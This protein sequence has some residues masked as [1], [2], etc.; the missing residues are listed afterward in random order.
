MTYTG[1][2]MAKKKVKTKPSTEKKVTR[3][4]DNL[5]D[6]YRALEKDLEDRELFDAYYVERK[7]SPA[8]ELKAA[9]E[10]GSEP[11]KILFSGQPKSGKTTELLRL[12][13]ELEETHLS[14]FMSVLRDLEP[15]DV[16]ALD[17]LLFSVI[18]LAGEAQEAGIKLGRDIKKLLTDLLLRSTSEVF[19]ERVITKAGGGKVGFK[20]PFA[21]AELG[22][23]YGIE[24]SLREVVRE[25]LGPKIGELVEVFNMVAAR[26]RQETG[27]EPLVVID[28]MEKLD[29]KLVDELFRLQAA[30]LARPKCRMIYTVSKAME[31]LP[32]WKMVL[33]SFD[34]LVEVYP[35]RIA[36]RDGAPHEDGLELLRNILRRRMSE[37]LFETDAFSKVV[38]VCNGVLSDLFSVCRDA[39]VSAKVAGT[40]RITWD[41]VD[42][43]AM[44]LTIHFQ[45]MI[46]ED[47]Y[48]VL[49]EVHKTRTGKKDEPLSKLLHMLAVIEYRDAEGIYYD[50]HPAVVPLLER[51]KLA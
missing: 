46:D 35:V 48:P 42:R 6:A 19:K 38:T 43:H 39:C 15:G 4:A 36:K 3:P 16:A 9:L 13:R 45:R 1:S 29:L 23:S 34:K 37:D 10:M 31:Y 7:Y 2:I 20:L 47:L 44:N 30:T 50:V 33:G 40:G 14:V 17:I 28:D 32:S 18:K 41:I 11:C 27:R 51:R 5:T 21:I 12:L 49:A 25:K 8:D 26:V 24:S 22:A